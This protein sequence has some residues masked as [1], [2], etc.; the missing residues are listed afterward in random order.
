MTKRQPNK[1]MDWEAIGKGIHRLRILRGESQEKLARLAG[2]GVSTIYHAEQGQPI[3][4]ASLLRICEAFDVPI[5]ELLRPK[6]S[7]SREKGF[8]VHRHPESIWIVAV[9]LRKSIPSDDFARIQNA[10][11][12]L[13]LGRLELV[14]AFCTTSSFI[15]PNGP[16]LTFIELFHRFEGGINE[17]IYREG[18]LRCDAGSVRLGLAGQIVELGAGDMVGYYSEDLKWAEPATPVGP[19]GFPVLLTWTGAVRYGNAPP[20]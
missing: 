17:G 16:G 9:D 10:E 3:R 2:I 18:I 11:E 5:E 19:T 15:M 6:Q 8:L 1:G 12:R 13:R 4:R 20:A 14:A 7:L